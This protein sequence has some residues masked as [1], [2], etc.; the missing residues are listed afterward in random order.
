V[1]KGWLSSDSD[2]FFSQF[3]SPPQQAKQIISKPAP[4]AAEANKST[5][6]KEEKK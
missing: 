3:L 6:A 5:G 4:N 2:D 1:S